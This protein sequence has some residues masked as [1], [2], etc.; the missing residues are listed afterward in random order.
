MHKKRLTMYMMLSMIIGI[1]LSACGMVEKI[2]ENE[3]VSAI[4]NKDTFIREM[5]FETKSIEE[6]RDSADAVLSELGTDNSMY[7][8]IASTSIVPII[9]E[10]NEIYNIKLVKK[11]NNN[12]SKAGDFD[13]LLSSEK[14]S[15]SLNIY[16]NDKTEYDRKLNI[17]KNIS[18]AELIQDVEQFLNTE[19]SNSPF[20]WYVEYLDIYTTKN[21][22]DYINVS[23][24]PAYDGVV[25]TRTLVLN[26]GLPTNTANDFR[27][28]LIN[29]TPDG[30]INEFYDINPDYTVEKQGEKITEILSLESVLSIIANKSDKKTINEIKLFELAYRLNKNLNA[31]PIWNIV[32]NE[33]GND[34]N[35]QIDA[36]T[37]DVYFE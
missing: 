30:E 16:R 27:G 17:S 32:I 21:K 29:I 28:G 20:K 37:G 31:V 2:E 24:R 9:T 8:N 34:R 14:K 19:Y 33:N 6:V 23:V 15:S 18:V 35:F 36:V 10:K 12:L 26:N 3:S 5:F 1:S 25:F 4:K 13:T 22:Q 11:E 7:G